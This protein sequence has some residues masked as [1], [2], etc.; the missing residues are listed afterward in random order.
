MDAIK[1]YF[2]GALTPRDPGS[3]KLR[4][5]SWNLNT[6]RFEGDWTPLAHHLRI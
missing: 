1:V 6:M 5:V 3:P 4:M 2:L